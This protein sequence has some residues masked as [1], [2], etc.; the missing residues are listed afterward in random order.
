VRVAVCEGQG[1]SGKQVKTGL[2]TH[3]E[4]GGLA[5]QTQAMKA[6]RAAIV[7]A[8]EVQHVN[9]I[10]ATKHMHAYHHWASPAFP[11]RR[12]HP[13]A[14]PGVRP[15]QQLGRAPPRPAV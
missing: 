4:K 7:S 9:R 3:R 5:A 1:Q 13:P 6:L 14:I 11:T 15:G 10:H 8:S 2:C 12:P